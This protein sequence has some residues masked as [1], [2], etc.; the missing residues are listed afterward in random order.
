MI[1]VE[2]AK[3]REERKEARAMITVERAEAREERKEARAM[4]TVERAK[5]REQRQE[6]TVATVERAA[7]ISENWLG[8]IPS[9]KMVTTMLN[10]TKAKEQVS[11]GI[12]AFV[13]YHHPNTN[14]SF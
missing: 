14:W 10:A 11:G 2:R 8:H 6:T 3:A 9:R 5:V 7:I 4:I 1:T 12:A 13:T